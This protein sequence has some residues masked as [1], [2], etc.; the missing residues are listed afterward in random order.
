MRKYQSFALRFVFF[1][2]IKFVTFRDKIIHVLWQIFLT[3]CQ[4]NR[5]FELLHMLDVATVTKNKES[6]F[7]KSSTSLFD[8]LFSADIKINIE[9]SRV[10]SNTNKT[11]I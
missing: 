3:K 9:H 10:S 5:T 6:S 7:L 11:G 2:H 8:Y 1:F 4:F